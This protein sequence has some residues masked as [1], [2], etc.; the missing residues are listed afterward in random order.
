MYYAAVEPRLGFVET[1]YTALEGEDSVAVCV[2]M[3][4]TTPEECV[5][6]FTVNV[7]FSTCDGTAGNNSHSIP[8]YCLMQCFSISVSTSDYIAEATTVIFEPCEVTQCVDVTV[9]DDCVL[10]MTE[11]IIVTL[12]LP[13]EL[14][15]RFKLDSGTTQISVIDNDG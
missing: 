12:T 4:N 2:E 14:E 9:V 6:N 13:S 10:E 5:A 1:L 11:T 8:T 3:K 15:P 7:T